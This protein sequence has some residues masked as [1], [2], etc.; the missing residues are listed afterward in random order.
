VCFLIPQ[1]LHISVKTTILRR[2]PSI[3]MET[4]ITNSWIQISLKLSL[5]LL[6]LLNIKV[7]TCRICCCAKNPVRGMER[8]KQNEKRILQKIKVFVKAQANP[9]NWKQMINIS[10]EGQ[11][12]YPKKNSPKGHRNV[13]KL[14]IFF[15]TKWF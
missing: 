11:S 15:K 8:V 7:V 1:P 6:T 14:H 10:V 3:H 4:T 13:S 9:L 12:V 5:F 2:T